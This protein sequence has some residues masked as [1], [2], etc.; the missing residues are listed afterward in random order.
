MFARRGKGKVLGSLY[1]KAGLTDDKG[2]VTILR[3]RKFA[4]IVY[5]RSKREKGVSVASEHG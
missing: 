5:G 4:D 1:R 2:R 3:F